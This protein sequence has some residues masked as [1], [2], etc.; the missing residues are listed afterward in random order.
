ML[1]YSTTV[2][3]TSPCAPRVE[4]VRRV[5]LARRGAVAVEFALTASLLFFI[6]FTAIE[7]MRVNSIVNSTENAA[8]EGARAAI[9]PGAN[10]QNAKDAA[11]AMVK[12]TGVRGATVDVQPTTINDDTPEVTVTVS[13]PLD[14][15][16]FIA[17]RFFL[18][19]TLTKTCT[20]SR[21]VSN[22]SVKNG[23]S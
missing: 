9:V 22:T 21:E 2:D 7:F 17:P 20:L 5:H 23:G 11:N 15:N 8:Y 1:E 12:A 4:G 18:G 13:V 16:S 3:P 6:V 19:D 10:D 14:K